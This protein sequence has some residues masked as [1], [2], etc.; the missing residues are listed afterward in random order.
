MV[1]RMEP[2]TLVKI[3]KHS[4]SIKM[5]K[6]PGRHSMLSMWKLNSCA[7]S[8]HPHSP[9]SRGTLMNPGLSGHPGTTD[10]PS[11]VSALGLISV[12]SLAPGPP[13]LQVT[14][15]HCTHETDRQV[16]FYQLPSLPISMQGIS[17][18]VYPHELWISERWSYH[19][20]F[21]K[22]TSPIHLNFLLF[23]EVH[24]ISM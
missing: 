2:L 4:L 11:I 22:S 7:S 5:S 17:A 23:A 9:C 1:A 21:G 10:A 19:C 12:C 24:I 3:R 18:E 20:S 6:S 16:L 8:C 13:G 14:V 15:N